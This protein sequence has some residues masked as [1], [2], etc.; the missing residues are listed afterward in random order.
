MTRP[1]STLPQQGYEELL[2][3]G[4]VIAR[5]VALLGQGDELRL[6]LL[7]HLLVECRERLLA[8]HLL[9][10]THLFQRELRQQRLG[11]DGLGLFIHRVLL[12]RCVAEPDET[13]A[14]ARLPLTVF[15]VVKLVV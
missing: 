3:A 1:S 2:G 8:H 6:E 12:G 4:A 7:T 11:E 15:L 14:D 10:R 5:G 13:R 9:H